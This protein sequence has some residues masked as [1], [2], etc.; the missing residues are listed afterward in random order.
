MSTA[1]DSWDP[2]RDFAF[3]EPALTIAANICAVP[4]RGRKL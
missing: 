1:L 2:A 4:G 3:W